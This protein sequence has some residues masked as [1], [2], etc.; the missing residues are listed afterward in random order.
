MPNTPRSSQGSTLEM[1]VETAIGV[2]GAYSHIRYNDGLAHD[3][4]SRDSVPNANKGHAHFANTDDMPVIYNA[5]KESA[6]TLPVGIRRG[7]TGADP[8]IVHLFRSCGCNVATTPATTVAVATSQTQITTTADIGGAANFNGRAINLE[9]DDIVGTGTIFPTLV[10]DYVT[11]TKVCIFQMGI[12]SIT[13]AARDIYK[14]YTITP[15]TRKVPVDK[16]LAF[17]RKTRLQH[18]AAPDMAWTYTGCAATPGSL[19]IT[20]N[21][22]PEWSWDVTAA[23]RE[24]GAVAL[25]N[26]VFSDTEILNAV[27][28]RASFGFAAYDANGAIAYACANIIEAEWN[29]GIKA[30]PI[31]GYGCTAQLGGLQGY[32][33]GY[34]PSTLRVVAVFDVTRWTEFET[35]PQAA[36]RYIHLVQPGSLVTDPCWGLWMPRAKMI[37]APTAD[38]SGKY[39]TA[40]ITWEASAARIDMGGIGPYGNDDETMAPWY[41]SMIGVA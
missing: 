20:P 30:E 37:N 29:P 14:T 26:E 34:E 33:A 12:P 16:T 8:P 32:M 24:V 23:K 40:E 15:R 19:S 9:L 13:A 5:Y 3:T 6:I 4:T 28:S 39:V 41:F 11:G 1:A 7:I 17:R 2:P 10:A 38:F 36:H 22:V 27:D 25:A 21:T 18:T 31:P 35:M